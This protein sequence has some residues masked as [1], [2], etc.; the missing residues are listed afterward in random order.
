MSVRLE[1]IQVNLNNKNNELN[2]TGLNVTEI[3][4]YNNGRASPASDPGAPSPIQSF[5]QKAK[6]VRK[7]VSQVFKRPSLPSLSFEELQ[8]TNLYELCDAYLQDP[9]P[10]ILKMIRQEVKSLGHKSPIVQT[11]RS[12]AEGVFENAAYTQEAKRE[13]NLVNAL[14]GSILSTGGRHT[15]K[16]KRHSHKKNTRRH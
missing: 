8:K 4:E 6:N 10:K 11:M 7:K 2:L 1:N 12:Y 15:R 16:R 13:K 3:E 5:F 14:G 9:S